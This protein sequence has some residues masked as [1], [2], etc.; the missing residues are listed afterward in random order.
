MLG[1]VG[2]G[3]L[4]FHSTLLWATQLADE[5]PMLWGMALAIRG[6]SVLS[7]GRG[8]RKWEGAL[9]WG[10]TAAATAAYVATGAFALFQAFFICLVAAAGALGLSA[11]LSLRGS[12]HAGQMA[13]L[14]CSGCGL[15]AL[16]FACWI[17]DNEACEGLRW[18]RDMLPAPSRPLLEMHGWW[19]LLSGTGLYLVITFGVLAE[20]AAKRV[21][22]EE[23]GG[24]RLRWDPL[25][26]APWVEL[27]EVV[28]YGG[29]ASEH[30]VFEGKASDAKDVD[31]PTVFVSGVIGDGGGV[32]HRI[33]RH[34]VVASEG[35]RFSGDH[36]LRQHG[37]A[38]SMVRSLS[39]YDLT[40]L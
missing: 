26:F 36:Q 37:P 40:A 7:R 14:F 32:R 24:V 4:L 19:H 6:F 30:P 34:R 28:A 27:T 5:L 16:A 9:L 11:L 22:G 13:A 35:G 18:A 39:V 15:F 25:P 1:V 23:L 33:I 21:R 20:E 17:A 3:S 8:Q 10:G 2:F 29:P 12:E 38:S 31:V